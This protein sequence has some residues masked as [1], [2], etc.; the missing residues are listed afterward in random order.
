MENTGNEKDQELLQVLSDVTS[1]VSKQACEEDDEEGDNDEEGDSVEDGDSREEGDSDNKCA[2]CGYI[3]DEGSDGDR[4]P[5]SEYGSAKEEITNRSHNSDT[6]DNSIVQKE[7]DGATVPERKECDIT[8]ND[9]GGKSEV[10]EAPAD[11][12]ECDVTEHEKRGVDEQKRDVNA[13][14]PA[15]CDVTE[16]RDVTQQ[17]FLITPQPH[18]TGNEQVIPSDLQLNSIVDLS[19]Q[20]LIDAQTGQAHNIDD[21]DISQFNE[22]FIVNPSVDNPLQEFQTVKIQLIEETV[23][24]KEEQENIDQ[25]VVEQIQVNVNT[26]VGDVQTKD[27][28]TGENEDSTN[29]EDAS[30]DKKCDVTVT[31]EKDDTTNPDDARTDTKCDNNNNTKETGE[32]SDVTNEKEG[33]N[34]NENDVKEDT[35]HEKKCDNPEK[36]CDVTEDNQVKEKVN[37]GTEEEKDKDNAKEENDTSESDIEVLAQ[38]K[39]KKKNI[40]VIDL[41]T[42]SSDE[43]KRDIIDE[44]TKEEQKRDII[45]E[46]AKEEQKRDVIDE[47][48]KE[49]Q[50]HDV[51]DEGV[52]RALKWQKV[53]RKIAMKRFYKGGKA[54]SSEGDVPEK[55]IE[56]QDGSLSDGDRHK[57]D[58]SPDKCVVTFLKNAVKIKDTVTPR[59]D[60]V[61]SQYRCGLARKFIRTEYRHKNINI[62]PEFDFFEDE[63]DLSPSSDTSSKD[64]TDETSATSDKQEVGGEVGGEEEDSVLY[65]TFFYC[66][67]NNINIID[68]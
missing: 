45:D 41:M 6:G 27:H 53:P 49:E 57:T 48:A 50:K 12:K 4:T 35:M 47:D 30:P 10:D 7:G 67:H 65:V 40:E 29:P 1:T 44:D 58:V 5:T 37:E 25:K 32:T 62:G 63:S 18:P 43:N 60:E 19:G 21:V 59:Q 17:P 22:V 24:I 55:E 68:F 33:E 31:E 52:K 13:T 8:D 46:D 14:L 56:K 42:S 51:I 36:N 28:V 26:Q 2:T 64:T 9:G 3:S 54:Y 20:M 11:Q 23:T 66:F 61:R 16:E 39:E 15:D 38:Y 34:D